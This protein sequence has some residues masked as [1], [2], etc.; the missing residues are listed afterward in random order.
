[1]L[2]QVFHCR[3]LTGCYDNSV[4]VWEV[5]GR[6]TLT[7]H[8]AHTAPVK[9]VKWISVCNKTALFASASQDQTA[10]IWEWNIE[11]NTA[12]CLIVFK[13][14]ERGVDALDTISSTQLLATGS[15]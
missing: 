12:D 6:H 3:I 14:H 10:K 15:W 2:K 9:D 4:N 5:S 7:I 1:M 8:A 13:G 11:S